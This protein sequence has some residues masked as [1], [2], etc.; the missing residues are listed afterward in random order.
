MDSGTDDEAIEVQRPNVVAV[1]RGPTKLEIEH[2]VAFGHA[3]HRTWCD[4]CMRARG[5]ARSYERREPDREDEDPLVAMD[6]GNLMLDG[7]EDDVVA[8]NKVLILVARTRKFETCCA[9]CLQE[10]GVSEYATSWLV[11]LLRRLGYRRLI[12][13]N[14]GEPSIVAFKTATLLA[15][16]FVEWVLREGPNGE[17]APNGVAESAMREVKR[18]TRAAV[19]HVT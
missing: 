18:R 2:P 7:T 14:D 13:Q 11:S 10:N 5:T 4:A 17:H 1:G 15:C 9:N 8:Q 6:H 19:L 12:L 3:Q 16:P